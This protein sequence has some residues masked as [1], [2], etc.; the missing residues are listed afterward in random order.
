[1][2]FLNLLYIWYLFLNNGFLIYFRK[3]TAEYNIL[4]NQIHFDCVFNLVT[5]H[6]LWNRLTVQTVC[7]PFVLSCVCVWPNLAKTEHTSEPHSSADA[8]VLPVVMS[9]RIFILNI[10][11]KCTLN[12]KRQL[13]D[14]RKNALKW[15]NNKN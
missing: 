13:W 3:F 6:L 2:H 8:L 11:W 9:R 7:G 12:V 15:H 14:S 10:L 1:M 4:K 5:T